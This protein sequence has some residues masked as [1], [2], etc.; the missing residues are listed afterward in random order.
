MSYFGFYLI[1]RQRNGKQI[2]LGRSRTQMVLGKAC[3][4][5]N[6][7]HLLINFEDYY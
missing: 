1:L 7:L 2:D 5:R 6:L 3:M 4:S